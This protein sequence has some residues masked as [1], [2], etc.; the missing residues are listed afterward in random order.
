[1]K[2]QQ[3]T[4][5][6][7]TDVVVIGA[8]YAGLTAALSLDHAGVD[9]IVVEADERVGGRV[10]T[11]RLKDGTVIDHGGQWVGPTQ[12]HLLA[13]AKR[14]SVKMFPTYTDGVNLELWNDGVT[15]EFKLVGPEGAPGMQEYEKAIERID[16][17]ASTINLDDPSRTANAEALD[18]ETVYSYFKRTV[19]DV[20]ARLRLALAVQ[21]VW[22]VEPRDISLLHL[23]FYVASAGSFEQLM[24]AENCAQD[25]RFVDGAQGI[26]IRIAEE[27]GDRVQ[28]GVRA[29]G[30][31]QN[32]HGVTVRT[33]QGTICAKRVISA[34]PPQA[35]A[36]LQ[37]FP[38]LP[39]ARARWIA[40]NP[41]GDVAKIHVGYPSPFWRE[42]GFSGEATVYGD[43]A[44]GVIF[45]NTPH[46]AKNGVLVCFVY[47]E[48]L[49]RWATLQD[50]QRK[51][52]VLETLT[53]IFG[54]D[55]ADPEW[56]TEKIW[57]QDEFVHGGYAAN[58]APGAWFEHGSAG[59]RTPVGH[60]YWA[61][62]E[63][64]SVWYGYIDGAVCSGERAA[65]E[66]LESLRDNY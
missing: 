44:V 53:N 11:Q 3:S 31:T 6:S 47:A 12:Q 65:E 17:L 50:D 61:G 43:P 13:L 7:V 24:E 20:D 21:G 28:L 19:S 62:T 59:W 18:S 40:K 48:R 41:M 33:D 39:L 22:T 42:H 36:K 49:H 56:Y 8:G 25:A 27:L 5:S 1:M 52:Q 60:I 51:Q 34:L 55:A 63:T 64:A 46:E 2:T 32:D 4:R 58:P 26:A 14:Y 35:T 10:Y 66:V 54:D 37:F 15:R 9:T 30:I 45:D 38:E 29:L 16:A 23:L 57:S